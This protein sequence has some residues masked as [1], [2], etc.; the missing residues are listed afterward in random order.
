METSGIAPAED[1]LCQA[2]SD[3]LLEV[4]DVDTEDGCDPNLCSE[5]VKDIYNYLKDLE[6]GFRNKEK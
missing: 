5:Y 6:V 2:F 3:V 4:K 1:I